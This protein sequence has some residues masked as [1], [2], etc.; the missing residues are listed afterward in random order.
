[1]GFSTDAIHAGQKP[2]PSTGAVTLPIYQ[3]STYVQPELGNP[4]DGHDYARAKNPT[5]T[6][7][8]AN[9]AALEQGKYGIAFSSGMATVT[10]LT[11]FLKAGDHVIVGNNTYGGVYR[12][13]EL[14][15]R[16]FDVDFSWI[17]TSDVENLKSEIRD[18][19]KMLYVESPTNPMLTLTDIQATS[20]ICKQND[21]IFVVD[22]TFMSPYFQRPLTLGADIVSHS[23]TKYLAGHS[24][25]IN[26]ILVTND[27][28]LNERL[29]FVQKTAGSI[30]SPF[31]CWLLLRSTKT[32][33]LR[34]RQHDENARTIAEWLEER[35][36]IVSV[37]YPG[38]ESHPQHELA[39]RQQLDPDGNPGFS[40]MISF[41]V[42]S[43]EKAKKVLDNVKIF[44]LAESLG[45]VESLIGH[46]AIQTHASVP[47]EE[48]EKL[49][50]TESLIR[51]SAGVEDVDDLIADLDQAMS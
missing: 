40:G 43:F 33:S 12:Y 47:K 49:G 9:I 17:D 1:M 44:S 5:R 29:K 41:D 46:P 18:N 37:N 23:T 11:G 28:K 8:E 36:D 6:A 3:T 7:V 34:M 14:M 48:R 22:N 51:L 13:F 19:T 2:D 25:L 16:D 38:L 30:P 4:I 26:G 24:D 42:G 50:I 32:L 45:G 27:E 35:A 21:I 15:I 10:A 20:E 31:D 39:K